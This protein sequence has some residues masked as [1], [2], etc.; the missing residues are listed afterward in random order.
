MSYLNVLWINHE[1]DLLDSTI[2]SEVAIAKQAGVNIDFADPRPAFGD[3]EAP[4]VPG[5][6]VCGQ[7]PWVNALMPNAS[8]FTPSSCKVGPSP[9]SP[10]SFHPNQDGQKAF[11]RTVMQIL[12]P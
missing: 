6:G 9:V 11:Y 5:H 10:C 3:N 7:S 1:T 12:A 8:P 2:K 4:A